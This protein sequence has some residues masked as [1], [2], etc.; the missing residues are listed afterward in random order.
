MEAELKRSREVKRETLNPV[1][2][3]EIV[4]LGKAESLALDA[5]NRD[6]SVKT[7]CCLH[8]GVADGIERQGRRRI[9]QAEHM[10]LGMQ[11]WGVP[12]MSDQPNQGDGQTAGV[13]G[14]GAGSG[15]VG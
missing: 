10:A 11:V 2:S 7:S 15:E 14:M 4:S 8:P 9:N 6:S 1:V 3:P 13:F 5:G 12:S